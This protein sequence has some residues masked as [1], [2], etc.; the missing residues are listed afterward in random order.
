MKRHAGI[1][2]SASP[3]SMLSSS[4]APQDPVR[5]SAQKIHINRLVLESIADKR[6][7]DHIFRSD[8]LNTRNLLRHYGGKNCGL[9]KLLHKLPVIAAEPQPRHALFFRRPGNPG[10]AGRQDCT[11]TLRTVGYAQPSEHL[12][13]AQEIDTERNSK[14]KKHMIRWI[15]LIAAALV[16]GTC[17]QDMVTHHSNDI[18]IARSAEIL[19]V[20]TITLIGY[21]VFL[22]PA[23]EA[24]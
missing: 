6:C 11:Q 3:Q 1:L 9:S 10:P 19:T 14:E 24:R 20:A 4:P 15:V 7:S 5:V 22:K 23:N 8:L 13:A 12:A 18:W 21:I 2:S 16:G 17:I